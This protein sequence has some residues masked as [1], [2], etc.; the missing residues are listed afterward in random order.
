MRND[1]CCVSISRFIRTRILITSHN[2]QCIS[3]TWENI[4]IIVIIQFYFHF[5]YLVLNICEWMAGKKNLSWRKR[6]LLSTVLLYVLEINTSL[7]LVNQFQVLWYLSRLIH[8]KPDPLLCSWLRAGRFILLKTNID[9]C[10]LVQRWIEFIS[11]LKLIDVN[12]IL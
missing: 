3:L 12:N 11:K 8:I 2:E 4:I 6:R 7:S 5:T 1:Y 9:T 10:F